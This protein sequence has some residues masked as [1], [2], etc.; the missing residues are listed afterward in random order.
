MNINIYICSKILYGKF[1]GIWRN[2]LNYEMRRYWFLLH[3][4][5]GIPAMKNTKRSYLDKNDVVSTFLKHFYFLFQAWDIF[6]VWLLRKM[7]P[8]PSS[9]LFGSIIFP[10]TKQRKDDSFTGS[11]EP[12]NER[13]RGA[14]VNDDEFERLGFG[15]WEE[16]IESPFESVK[17]VRAVVDADH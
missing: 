6:S 4:H 11:G 17:A 8:F 14:S 10:R 2:P 15:G 12:D 1:K 16:M 7:D 13:Q 9:V 5:T 3:I